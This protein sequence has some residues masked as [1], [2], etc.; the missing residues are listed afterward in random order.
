MS[1]DRNASL[2]H[3]A[4]PTLSRWLAILA[5][6]FSIIFGAAAYGTPFLILGAVIQP[7]AP[8][9]GRWLVWIGALLL[10]L[11]VF[12]FGPGVLYEQARSLDRGGK[13][14]T[15]VLF[16][17][18]LVLVSVCDIMLVIDALRLNSRLMVR[19]SLDWLAWIAAGVLTAG[20]IWIAS[21]VTR[22]TGYGPGFQ[23]DRVLQIGLGLTVVLFDVALIIHAITVRRLV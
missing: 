10:S 12:S 5:A 9:T 7:R 13:V 14:D 17:V 18:S 21:L 15:F 2:G 8:T 3:G 16:L 4:M 23:L 11:T 20:C 6:C 1:N 22:G 19:G